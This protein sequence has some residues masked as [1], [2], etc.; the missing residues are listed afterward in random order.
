M[1]AFADE[2]AIGFWDNSVN[3]RYLVLTPCW[4]ECGPLLFVIS[5]HLCALGRCLVPINPN[6][7]P[8]GDNAN[9]GT[10][11]LHAVLKRMIPCRQ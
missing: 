10:G 8:S 11:Y 7:C 5:R 1:N 4:Y 6:G 2:A 3:L 9:L